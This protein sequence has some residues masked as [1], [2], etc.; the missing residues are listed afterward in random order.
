MTHDPYTIK[1]IDPDVLEVPEPDAQNGAWVNRRNAIFL[2]SGIAAGLL[3]AF[4]F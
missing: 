1:R 3:L 2:C 4:I